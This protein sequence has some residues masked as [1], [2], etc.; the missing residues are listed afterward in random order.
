MR[1]RCSF[2]SLV[3][4]IVNTANDVVSLSCRSEGAGEKAQDTHA[5]RS[6]RVYDVAEWLDLRENGIA[7]RQNE[8]KRRTVGPSSGANY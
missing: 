5:E 3:I 1:R 4:F 2:Y 7:W 8:R 6:T